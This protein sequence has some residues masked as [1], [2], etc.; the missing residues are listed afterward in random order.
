MK[1][2]KFICLGLLFLAGTV[3]GLRAGPYRTDINPATGKRVI[4]KT[5]SG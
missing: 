4:L 5:V 1:T 2:T 3:S